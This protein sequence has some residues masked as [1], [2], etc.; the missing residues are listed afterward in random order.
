MLDLERPRTPHVFAASRQE[1]LI[2]DYCKRISLSDKNG[3][4]F[5]LEV[6]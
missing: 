4:L 5:M 1:D 2:L 6:I 3:R